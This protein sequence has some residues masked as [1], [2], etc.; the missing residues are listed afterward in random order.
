MTV[1]SQAK[2]GSLEALS[3]YGCRKVNVEALQCLARA[4]WPR[5]SHLNVGMIGAVEHAMY[6]GVLCQPK[7]PLLTVVNVMCIKLSVDAVAHLVHGMS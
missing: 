6:M 5:L 3:I 1:L 2:W 7:W 4:E